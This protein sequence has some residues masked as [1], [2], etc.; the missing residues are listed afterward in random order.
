MENKN[1]FFILDPDN[2]ST[3]DTDGLEL[4]SPV[5]KYKV[6]DRAS[7]K[8]KGRPKKTDYAWLTLIELY[9]RTI[10]FHSASILQNAFKTTFT[11]L[12]DKNVE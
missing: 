9:E 12:S 2:L 11:P 5:T 3:E 6:I 10:N 1:P 8:G 7:Y 4:F